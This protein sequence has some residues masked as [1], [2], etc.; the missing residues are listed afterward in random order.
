M[1]CPDVCT[2]ER[3][4]VWGCFEAALDGRPGFVGDSRVRDDAWFERSH[5]MGR[6]EWE[7]GAQLYTDAEEWGYE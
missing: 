1:I 6:E 7:A 3:C 4:R 5:G 2:D